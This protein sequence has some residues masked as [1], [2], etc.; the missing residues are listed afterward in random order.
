MI[1]PPPSE[2]GAVQVTA[3]CPSPTVPETAVGAP[4]GSGTETV[5]V[6]LKAVDEI[7]DHEAPPSVDCLAVKVGAGETELLGGPA[8][9][10]QPI[11]PPAD[12]VRTTKYCVDALRA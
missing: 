8:V 7:V 5:T 6:M 11:V 12:P 10:F 3:T 4:G 2:L 1:A 9:Y